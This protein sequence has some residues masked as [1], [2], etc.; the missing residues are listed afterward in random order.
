[1]TVLCSL[2]D[3]IGWITLNRPDRMNAISTELARDLAAAVVAFDADP[4]VNVIVVRGAGGNFC[5]GG[6]FDEVQ[7]LRAQGAA[8]LTGLFAAFRDACDAIGAAR[9]PVIAAVDG[10]AAAGGFELMQAADL[11]LI[12]TD[13][14]VA[15]NHVKFGMVPGGGGS[16]RLPRLVGRQQAMGLLLSGDRISGAEAVALGLAYRAYPTGDFDA[17]VAEFARTLAGRD[18]QAVTTIKRLVRAGL[19]ATPAAAVATEIDTVVAHILG[20]AGASSTEQFATR[21]HSRAPGS[22]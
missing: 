4:A 2:D 5:A 22:K 13:A 14:R 11:T 6:D 12:S 10:V 18:R 16:V 3:G 19:E 9:V 8:A 17:A 1:M 7:R 15:D 20:P 21:D